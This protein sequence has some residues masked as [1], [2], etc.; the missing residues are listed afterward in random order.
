MN[1]KTLK[2]GG[3][4]LHY[5]DEGAGPVLVFVQG[6]WVSRDLWS[7]TIEALGPNFRCIS[8]DWPL[9]GHPEPFA[10]GADLSPTGIATLVLDFI[11]ALDLNDVTLVGNDTGA[12]VC[13]LVITA[14]HPAVQRIG[15]LALTN[16]DSYDNFPPKAF[17]PVQT[18][19]RYVPWIANILIARMAGGETGASNFMSSVCAK[20]VDPATAV[21]LLANFAASRGSRVDSLKFLAK[22]DATKT[23]LPAAAKFGAFNRPVLL[24][25]GEDDVFFPPSDGKR[26]AEAF[27]NTKLV[28]VTECKTFVP[29]DHPGLLARELNDFING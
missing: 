25:W 12:A 20:P 5:R 6:V 8:V 18:M 10:R 17:K 28:P 11:E 26:L 3:G 22:A 27:P 19:A 21:K 23:T 2:V 29:L 16:A 4:T 9:G 24:V 1:D 14:E 7:D 13:Q 15:R